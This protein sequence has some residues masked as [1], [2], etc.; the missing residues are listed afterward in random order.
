VAPL[1][2]YHKGRLGVAS[3]S[4]QHVARLS[5]RVPKSVQKKIKGKDKVLPASFSFMEVQGLHQ[6]NKLKLSSCEAYPTDGQQV[7]SGRRHQGGKL[8]IA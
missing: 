3:K 2:L 1:F 6:E 7:W 8:S 5:V 4:R